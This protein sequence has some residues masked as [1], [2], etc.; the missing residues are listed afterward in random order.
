MVNIIKK[1]GKWPAPKLRNLG[2]EKKQENYL[3]NKILYQLILRVK[4]TA[5]Q[6]LKY[7]LNS[8]TQKVKYFPQ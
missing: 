7:I 8:D 1:Q 2:K 5:F 3:E 6:I 4:N